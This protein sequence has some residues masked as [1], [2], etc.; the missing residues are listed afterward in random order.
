M[1]RAQ[2]VFVR[3]ELQQFLFDFKHG[4]AGCEFGAVAD[5]IDV[6]VYGNG[7][8]AKRSVQNHVSGFAAHSGQG[9]QISSVVRHLTAMLLE[10]DAA[11]LDD[12]LGLGVKQTDGF[13]LGL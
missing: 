2:F 11:G 7:R 9:F 12:V 3:G 5:T 1:V 13:N 8:L 10:Q 4:F 6:S